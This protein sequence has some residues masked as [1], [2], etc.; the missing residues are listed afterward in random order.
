[1]VKA[2][3]NN[4]GFEGAKKELLRNNPDCQM[5]R[6][7]YN[8]I[9][10]DLINRSYKE[11]ERLVGK[12]ASYSERNSSHFILMNFRKHFEPNIILIFE[13]LLKSVCTPSEKPSFTEAC[14]LISA[15]ERIIRNVEEIKTKERTHHRK[16]LGKSIETEGKIR[17]NKFDLHRLWNSKFEEELLRMYQ[18][19]NQV[20]NIRDFLR[21][22]YPR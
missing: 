7:D 4:S 1:M 8:S 18:E 6:N 20:S 10:Q 17:G 16:L 14:Q 22:K 3:F 19:G 5:N 2:F 13:T 12:K 11:A 15:I 21:N 9:I